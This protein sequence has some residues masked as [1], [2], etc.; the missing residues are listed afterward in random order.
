MDTIL[1]IL[2]TV[3][4]LGVLIFIHEFGHFIVAKLGKIQV[5]EFSLGMGPR[6]IKFKKGETEYSLRAFPIGGFVSMEG[7]NGEEESAENPRAFTRRPKWIRGLTLIAGA[8]MNIILGFVIILGLVCASDL[9]GTTKIAGFHKEATSNQIL[10]QN[11][12]IL[13]INGMKIHIDNDIVFALVRDEDGLVDFTVRRNGEMVELKDVPFTMKEN[14]DG[15]KSIYLDFQVYGVEKTFGGVIKQAIG[16]T[17]SIIR[18]V[19]VSLVELVTGQYAIS[20]LSGPVGVASAVGQASSAGLDSLFLLVAFI[21]LNLG[22]FNLL[23][24]PALD[25]GRI[26]LLI[27]EAIRRKP[28]HPKYEG[29]IN[30]A[31]L[32]VLLLFML[33]VTFS[34]ITKLF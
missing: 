5:N 2:K 9:I 14:E 27:I 22:V 18:T 7:E 6:I 25:G 8:T 20:D 30:F 3:I 24:F 31:G 17:V 10:M 32:A 23:P 34:D 29:F 26:V 19:W 16:W 4:I 15:T 28:L 11:D 1:T 33:V 21:T 13:K 12:E